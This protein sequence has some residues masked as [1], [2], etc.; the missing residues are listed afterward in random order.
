MTE[1]L[2]NVE[3]RKK[4]GYAV[5]EIQRADVRNAIDEETAIELRDAWRRFDNDDEADV[6][7]LTG[8]GGHFSAGADLEKMD[9]TDKETGFLGFTRM[10]VDKPTI[11]AIDGYC[12]AGGLEMAL[13]CDI[14]VASSDAVLGCLERRYGVPLVDGGTQRLPR[15]IGTGRALEMILTGREVDA[16][17]AHGWGLVNEVV[18]DE[19]LDRAVEFAELISSFPQKT[20]RTDRAALYDGLGENIE[21]AL[22]IEAWH[23][24]RSLGVAERGARQ[25]R[26]EE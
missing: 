6:G 8:S 10:Q 12:V 17:E 22:R 7:I 24:S 3:Y 14:R 9:L 11:A 4:D 21:N 15:V 5:I 16:E 20:V 1:E 25:F 26:E 13:W 19:S 18:E 2:E 23:G